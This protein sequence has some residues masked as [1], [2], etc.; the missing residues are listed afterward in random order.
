MGQ[1]SLI[2]LVDLMVGSI[3]LAPENVLLLLQVCTILWDHYTVLVQ[4]Q[5][6]EMLVHLI[7]ELV[8]S[9]IEDD[10]TEPKKEKIEDF[11]EAIR[12]HKSEVVWSY[13]ESN[14]KDEE[15][16]GNRV[17]VAMNYV[18]NEVI[19]LFALTYPDIH[20]KWAKET[21]SWATSCSVRHLACRSFQI[22]RCILSSLNGAMLADMLARLSNTVA[23][24]A[25]EVQTFS[26]EILTTLKTIIAALEPA[27][28]LKYP[29]LF[30]AT[31]ACLNT[32]NECE[33][34]ETLSMLDKL[35]GKV[36]FS[37][38]AVLKILSDAKP[39]KWEGTFEGVMPL[40]Y[41]GLKSANSLQKTLNIIALTS[42]LPDSDLI[43][44]NQIRLL[45]GILANLPRFLHTFSVTT[46]DPESVTTAKSFA[47][48]AES[49]G[50]QE[51]TIVLNTF[52]NSRYPSSGDFLTQILLTVQQ[53]FFPAYELKSLVFL[54][55]FLTNRLPWYKLKTMQ[56]LCALIPRIDMRRPEVAC[57]GP[58][59]ISPLLRLLQTEY[60]PQALEV[61]DHI[62]TI[63][64]SATPMDSQH[65]RMSMLSSGSRSVRKEYE[66]TQSLYGI[67]QDTGWSIPMPAIQ[68]SIT[69]ANVHAVFYTCATANPSGTTAAATP[70][71]E[72][73]AEDFQ[74]G[75]YF[76][77]ER[78]DTMM[79]EDTRV[80]PNYD[81]S[82]DLVSKLD[83]LDDFF[84]E[85]DGGDV[86]YPSGYSD[87]TVTGYPLDPDNDAELYDQQTAP[88][89]NMSLART[90]SVS[91]LH[92]NFA[93]SRTATSAPLTREAIPMNPAAFATNLPTSAPQLRPS[94]HSRSITSPSNSFL[95]PG[96]S[97]LLSDSEADE[98]F[99]DDERSTGNKTKNNES[100]LSMET[101]I[102]RTKTSARRLTP[103]AT[104]TEFRK[105]DF[106]KA[107]SRARSKSHAPNSPEVPK[108]PEAYL[109]A[110]KA[111]DV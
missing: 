72:F 80:D 64:A 14:G 75:S 66:R 74:N 45:Y 33:F 31:C 90:A 19:N 53:S 51:I 89:L 81:S 56:I 62:L 6:R 87:V 95:R 57:H 36:N 18:T 40:V 29:Q 10:T 37:D 100:A 93:D 68:S 84:E 71:I 82:V 85:D 43:G 88:I 47:A 42:T 61:M 52:A 28:L 76:P 106:L 77:L 99:S 17:P 105:K 102:R 48:V 108:V 111:A 9:K 83:S 107:Q 92:S 32:V 39:E 12:Q 103:V 5:A 63:S 69:R 3:H 54:M 79:S 67:P 11:V 26:M 20:E 97:E 22:F 1:L 49:S 15:E 78:S 34:I 46:K 98:V 109:Q 8:I 7:H 16:D 27:D 38:P 110:M 30:W 25:P 23:D 59:L 94:L 60:C 104:G 58:D 24:E 73:D 86:K 44:N 65:L 4:E 50:Y 2:L 35:L 101:M 96:A 13:Q 55:G 21:L 41:K 91:S 70:E